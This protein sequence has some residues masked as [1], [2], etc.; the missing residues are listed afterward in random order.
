M[1]IRP[2][3]LQVL[4]PR[5]TEVSKVQQVAD[6]QTVLQQQQSAAALQQLAANRQH[7]VQQSPRG[8][9]G[10]VDPD[11]QQENK[12]RDSYNGKG[13]RR[14]ENDAEEDTDPIRG[15]TIDIKT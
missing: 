12:R 6:Q 15:H 14:R 7:Q 8:T 1:N 9:G 13:R 5:T 11:A 10:K 4:I 2:I 3:D